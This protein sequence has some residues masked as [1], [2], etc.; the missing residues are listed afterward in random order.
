MDCVQKLLIK[1]VITIRFF[2]LIIYYENP[3]IV[4]KNNSEKNTQSFQDWHLANFNWYESSYI[5]NRLKIF[6]N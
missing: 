2:I 4:K 3:F 1:I 6:L 5:L